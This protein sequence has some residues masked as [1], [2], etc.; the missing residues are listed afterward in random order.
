[1]TA[2]VAPDSGNVVSLRPRVPAEI[3]LLA[4][5]LRASGLG[6]DFCRWQVSDTETWE[7]AAALL[8]VPSPRAGD[9]WQTHRS[10]SS[11]APCSGNCGCSCHSPATDTRTAA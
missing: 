3:A 8:D 10:C 9:G 1:M 11:C 4:G 5:A 6:P 2:T 7:Q